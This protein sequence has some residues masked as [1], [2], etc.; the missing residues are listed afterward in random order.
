MNGSA[1]PTER[2]TWD[3]GE[4]ARRYL[5]AAAL[6]L[7][8][9]FASAWATVALLRTSHALCDWHSDGAAD[10]GSWGCPDG[11]SYTIPALLGAEAGAGLALATVATVTARHADAATIARMA[12]HAIGLLTTAL[13]PVAL[14][15]LLAIVFG[16]WPPGWTAWQALLL[17]VAAV[18]AALAILPPLLV[19]L[20]PEQMPNVLWWIGLL[21]VLYSATYAAHE[22]VLLLPAAAGAIGGWLLALALHAYAARVKRIQMLSTSSTKTIEGPRDLR[23]D[24][25]DSAH[26]TQRD[27]HDQ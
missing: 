2:H 26:E 25:T 9:G 16:N 7:F 13:A 15:C 4:L 19:T 24:R 6:A 8:A 11:I 22:S 5:T 20:R 18:T 1:V 3:S 21:A 17:A 12:R 27:D 14:A 23:Q 10:S